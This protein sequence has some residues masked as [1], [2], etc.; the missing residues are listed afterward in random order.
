M[1]ALDRRKNNEGEDTNKLNIRKA[2][3]DRIFED[4][5]KIDWEN[6]FLVKSALH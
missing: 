5:E 4:F 6:I 2:K 1:G 3:F